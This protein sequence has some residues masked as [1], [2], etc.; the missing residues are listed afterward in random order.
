MATE[1]PTEGRCNAPAWLNEQER[2]AAGTS[3][4]GY[5]ETYPVNGSD[6]CRMHFGTADRDGVRGASE[7]NG[8]GITHGATASPVNLKEHLEPAEAQWVESLVTG[9]LA[10]APFGRNDPRRERLTRVCVMIF[11]EWS[12]SER[13]LIEGMTVERTVGYSDSGYEITRDDE[14]H[15]NRVALKINDKIRH[16]LKD[17]G[18]YPSGSAEQETVS[19]IFAAAV[20]RA[21]EQ[22]QSD[23]E[24]E[25]SEQADEAE[26]VEAESVSD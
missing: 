10:I 26:Y 4:S 14:H 16:N 19:Q 5:C 1:T 18:C 22:E 12:A 25:D 20:E 6:T 2:Q 9:Y 11:Q 24:P 3:K 17:L 8:N 23:G 15:L 21:K 7:G 13:V